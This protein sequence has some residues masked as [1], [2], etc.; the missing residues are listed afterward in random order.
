MAGLHQCS[1]QC[2]IGL[3]IALRTNG[4]NQDLHVDTLLAN[5]AIHAHAFR[6]S[7]E[8]AAL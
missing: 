6:T 5:A 8:M 3:N 7:R 2:D 4:H 1:A